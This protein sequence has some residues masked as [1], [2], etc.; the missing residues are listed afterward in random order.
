MSHDLVKGLGK[1]KRLIVLGVA[2]AVLALYIVP[3]DQIGVIAGKSKV[4]SGG[5]D[6]NGGNGDKGKKET[7]DKGGKGDKGDKKGD[8]EDKGKKEKDNN[9]E[10]GLPPHKNGHSDNGNHYG[11][12]KH[13]DD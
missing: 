2:I 6:T 1:H 5:E 3:L 10:N 9:C 12:L 13:L 4:T 11:C 7:G 8:K